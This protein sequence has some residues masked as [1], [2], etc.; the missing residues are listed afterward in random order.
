MGS[1]KQANHLRPLGLTL[2]LNPLQAIL[3]FRYERFGGRIRQCVV[4]R[5]E[6]Q[7]TSE[8]RNVGDADGQEI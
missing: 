5:P 8:L 1:L 2:A 7:V 6:L 4:I 3:S